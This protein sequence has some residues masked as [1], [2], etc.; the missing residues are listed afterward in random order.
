MKQLSK[1][2][3]FFII[4]AAVFV[5]GIACTAAGAASGGVQGFEKLAERYDWINSPGERGVTAQNVGDFH[6]I[7][8]TGDVDLWIVGKSYY[9]KAGWLADQDL[10]KQTELDVIG[11]GQVCV[12]AGDQ[13]EQPQISVEKGVLTIDAGAIDLTGINLNVTEAEFYPEVLVCVPDETLRTLTV[14][15][16]TGDVN[17]LGVSW[18]SA[19]IGVNTGDISME[20]VDSKALA[21]SVDTGDIEVQGKLTGTVEA[22]SE[23]GDI[24][25]ATSLP[26]EKYALDLKTDVG[27]IKVLEGG[28]KTFESEEGK[29]MTQKGG[30]HRIKVSTDTG[31]VKL[32][33]ESRAL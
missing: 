23:T 20:G 16:Q 28:E 4:C 26:K 15:G 10:L 29:P 2:A 11:S 24:E 6:S 17:V 12:I 9:E 8:A 1:L 3:K 30:P 5:I 27:D 31:D 14:S 19:K 13:M 22:G 25:I 21:L 32:L 33:F 18:K 7:E